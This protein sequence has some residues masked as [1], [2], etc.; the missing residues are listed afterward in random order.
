MAA[1]GETS[2]VRA[3]H[4]CTDATIITV[5]MEDALALAGLVVA[6]IA[7]AVAK[8]TGWYAL[9]G[10]ASILIGAMLM[11]FAF[12]L[13]MKLKS[14]LLGEGLSSRAVERIRT[15]ITADPLVRS[16]V[17]VRTLVLGAD[18][19]LVA[20]DVVFEPATT[21]AELEA[22]VDRIEARIRGVVPGARCYI[23]AESLKA[24]LNA[25]GLVTS[26]HAP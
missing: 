23:E 8:A 18:E 15:T 6:G 7:I 26:R 17:D 24:P 3:F 25:D 2:L 21:V 10:Y 12:V 20:V 14:M 11:V 1:E 5:L 16:V 19:A 13:A 22:V 9:D 4:D